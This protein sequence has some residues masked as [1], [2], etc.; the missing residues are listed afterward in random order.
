MGSPDYSELGQ[1]RRIDVIE[2]GNVLNYVMCFDAEGVSSTTA[3]LEHLKKEASRGYFSKWRG[4]K[5]VWESHHVLPWSVCVMCCK[6]LLVS[7]P[8][9]E[10]TMLL[11][12]Y[13]AGPTS[14]CMSSLTMAF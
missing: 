14:D 8:K 7:L 2:Y 5:M 12:Y 13:H 10:A 1:V 11:R 3:M 9:D 6:P 4:G